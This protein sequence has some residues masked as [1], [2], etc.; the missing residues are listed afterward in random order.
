MI[1]SLSTIKTHLR[2]DH[3]DEDEYLEDLVQAATEA[4]AD[5]LNWT[6]AEILATTPAPVVSAILLLIADLYENRELQADR[7]LYSNDTYERLLAPY[8]VMGV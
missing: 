3:D 1:T 7:Q 2:I 4:T 8:R 6:S 5:Y